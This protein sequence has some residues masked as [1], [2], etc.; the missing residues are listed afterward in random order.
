MVAD[1]KPEKTHALQEVKITQTFEL[2]AQTIS[3][4]IH[5]RSVDELKGIGGPDTIAGLLQTD[6]QHGI[7]SAEATN[8]YEERIQT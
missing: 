4:V 1:W 7:P 6:L 2:P 8:D 3:S 5:S